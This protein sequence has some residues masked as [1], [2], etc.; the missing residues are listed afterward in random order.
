MVVAR[1]PLEVCGFTMDTFVLELD[2]IGKSFGKQRIIGGVSI[3]IHRGE[4]ITL[5]GPSGCGKTT[6]LR[7][8]A[9]LETADEGRVL[10]NGEDVTAFAP[11]R[12]NV[13]TVFQ[14]Y[15]LFPHM[16]VFDNIAYGPRIRRVAKKE[17]PVLV[18]EMLTLV[19]MEGYGKRMPNQLSGG[20]RQRIAIARALI[21]RPDVV[22]LDEP[23]GALDLQLRRHMQSEL[24]QIQKKAG[25]TFIYVTHD[26]EEALNMSDRLA[27][28]NAGILEQVG[29]PEEIYNHP[30]TRFVAEF[31]GTRNLLPVTVTGKNSAA[32]SGQVIPVAVH[33]YAEGEG[34]FAA[35]HADKMRLQKESDGFALPCIVTD[36]VYSGG[37]VKTKVVV[38]G[39]ECTVIEYNA[40]KRFAPGDAAFVSW[41]ADEAVMVRDGGKE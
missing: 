6:T 24:K 28:M 37:Q 38:N 9:G 36:V 10:L 15:A 23:L 34:A 2:G 31:V 1:N 13:N 27:I 29:S 14:N 32:F 30:A 8:I 19:Q 41:D 5:L 20:Q 21:N 17:I 4:F 7:V 35:I 16:N 11:D 26:Q 18:E 12:R 39:Q 22:L 33:M 25:V 3:R 40:P